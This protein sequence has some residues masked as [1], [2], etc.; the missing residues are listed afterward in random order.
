MAFVKHGQAFNAAQVHTF[1]MTLE[2]QRVS[3]RCEQQLCV[4]VWGW[5]GGGVE[6]ACICLIVYY[7]AAQYS[8]SSVN[9]HFRN[10]LTYVTHI[11]TYICT[12]IHKCIYV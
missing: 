11:R 1:G 4:Y 10:M 8:V 9:G 12:F 7:S 5:G 2:L 3:G 6:G